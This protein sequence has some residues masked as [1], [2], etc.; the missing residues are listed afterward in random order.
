MRPQQA[1]PTP[2]T[3]NLIWQFAFTH[4]RKNSRVDSIEL[5]D[6]CAKVG[7]KGKGSA[8]ASLSED[9]VA[10]AARSLRQSLVVFCRREGQRS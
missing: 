2:R 9:D 10:K 5:V 7:I 8:L 3:E 1:S 4:W 6:V